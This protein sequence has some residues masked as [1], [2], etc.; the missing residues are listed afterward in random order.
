MGSTLDFKAACKRIKVHPSEHGTLLFEWKGLLRYFAVCHFGAK[1]SVYRWQRLGALL[2]RI[3]HSIRADAP[4]R[5]WLYVDDL[6][7]LL[8]TAQHAEQAALVIAWLAA[9]EAPISW[10]KTQLGHTVTWCG[11]TFDFSQETVHLTAEKLV[12]LRAQLHSLASSKKFRKSFAKD[13][14]NA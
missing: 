5:A 12:K 13:W 6:L 4:H 8:Q 1:F 10:R 7:L 9:I 14:S 11:W 3:T 2:T